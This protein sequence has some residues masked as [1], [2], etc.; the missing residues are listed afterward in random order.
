MSSYQP[1]KI[2]HE[3][4][5]ALLAYSPLVRR[6]LQA[7]HIT[8]D[9]EAEIFLNPN[10]ERDTHDPFLMKDMKKIVKRI[11]HAIAHS[12]KIVLW[13]DYDMDGIP[14][15]VLLYDFFK[16]IGYEH[17]QHY[18]PH[19]NKE[20]FGLNTQG[21]DEMAEKGATLII[22][23][24]CGTNDVE[25]VAYAREKNIDVIITDH[26]LPLEVLPDAYAILNPKQKDCAYEEEMLCGAG[27][28]FKLVQAMLVSLRMENSSALQIPTSGWEKWLLDMVGMATVADM[29]PLI[30]ENRA[31]AYFGLV[32]LRKSRRLGLHALFKKA[33]AN[34]RNLTEDDIGFT[35]APRINAASRM[36]HAKDA[37]T[38]LASTDVLE[39]EALAHK[40]E[41]INN[42]RKII[43]ATMKREIK[44]KLDKLSDL[45]PVIVLGNPEWKPSLLGLVAGSL[46][47]EYKRPI[48]LWGREEGVIIKGSCRS[49]GSCSVFDLMSE[50]SERFIEFG[51]HAFSGGFS[52][53]DAQVHTL[54]S[55]LSDAYIRIAQ[56]EHS[57]HKVYDEVLL[58]DDV[59][60]STYKEVA[61]FAPFGKGNE[62]PVFLFH[63]AVLEHVRTFGKGNEHLEFSFK[64]TDGNLV[65]AI[66]FFTSLDAFGF[67]FHSGIR[68][69]FVANFEASYFMGKTELRLRLIEILHA[70]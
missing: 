13:S 46:T 34:Q 41:S 40:L 64:K 42:E 60:W 17:V 19:R 65:K 6:L 18:T 24:D 11:L 53:E 52:L 23:I 57:E 43:V 4:E 8:T 29:V 31:L 68:L 67:E 1:R 59:I 5:G 70:K 22:T 9:S 56:N 3:T 7:R 51:G 55:V 16:T 12:E 36:G 21:I 69:T 15:A 28:V 47:E 49:D 10:W 50:V 20:G 66:R 37:F 44:R 39:A 25:H 58:I 45:K 48:F 14:G 33:R 26:H 54:E 38:L 61:R 2:Q 32:V 63:E 62:K 30:G 35:I 27:V